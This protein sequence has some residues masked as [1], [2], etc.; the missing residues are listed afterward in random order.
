MVVL[1]SGGIDSAVTLAWSIREGYEPY[2]LTVYYGQRHRQ[3]VQAARR[4][5]RAGGVKHH[6]LVRWGSVASLLRSAL[7]QDLPIPKGEWRSTRETIP[8]TY[9]PARN[10]LLL[11]LASGWAESLGA[12]GV[13]IG[14]NAVDFAGYPDCR[15]QFLDAFQ[16][17]LSVGTK[18]GVEG[19]PVNIFAPLIHL[20]KG[21]IIRL[22]HQWGVNFALTLSCYD[23]SPEGYACG[24]CDS[25]LIRKK[26][27]REAGIPDPT[28]YLR[29]P[30]LRDES[31]S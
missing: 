10:A 13:A 18:R 7:T 22:G 20:S 31:S 30:Y 25:C 14:V 12:E 24:E 23:P 9:V 3:E 15:P 5:A 29:V 6:R 27:F 19:D 1:L 17:M 2:A 11:S 4:V 21:E 28:P 26:G 8:P 16:Q